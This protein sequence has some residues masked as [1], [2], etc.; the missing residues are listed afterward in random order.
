[1][2]KLLSMAQPILPLVDRILDGRTAELLRSWREEGL[3]FD[4]IARR[5]EARHAI[6]VTGE[7]VRTWCADLLADEPTEAAS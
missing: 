6:T 5:L 1:M 2:P 7:T 4:A 3:S